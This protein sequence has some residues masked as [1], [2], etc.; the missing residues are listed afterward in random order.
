MNKQEINHI[1]YEGNFPPRF[2][3]QKYPYGFFTNTILSLKK[4][5]R[6]MNKQEINHIFHEGNFPPRFTAQKYPYGFLRIKYYH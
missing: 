4:R 3:A 6:I 5:S 2:T 1:F